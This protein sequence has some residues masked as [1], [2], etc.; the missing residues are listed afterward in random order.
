MGTIPIHLPILQ[1]WSCHNC[2][3][4]CREHAIYITEEERDRI[5]AQ[6][7]TPAQGIPADQPIFNTER[8]WFAKPRIRL[9]HQADG[10]CVFLDDQGLC[11]IHG[12]FGEAA[13]PLAC[14]L[15]P[16]VFHPSGDGVTV[17]LRFSCPSVADNLGAPVQKQQKEIAALADGVLPKPYR[18]PEAPL[19]TDKTRLIWSDTMVV[20]EAL[21]GAFADSETPVQLQLLRALFWMD[22]VQQA[23]F[24]KISGERLAELLTLLKEASAVELPMLPETRPITELITRIQFRQLAG[25]Y[26]RKDT[27]ANIDTSIRGR[28]EL[29][30]TAVQLAG[31]TGGDLPSLGEGLKPVPIQT[32]DESFGE[33]PDRSVEMFRRY[34]RVK[35]QGLH[36]CGPAYYDQPMTE[37]FQALALA[38]AATLWIAKWLAASDGRSEW[39]HADL[40]AALNLI[41]HQHGYSPALGTWEARRRIKNFAATGQIVNLVLYTSLNRPFESRK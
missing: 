12:K 29:L 34:F 6:N 38:F 4:C 10:G 37:G 8:S 33:L 16:Y 20:I 7:W 21:D 1:N 30:K 3:G 23:K 11:R 22:L 31:L 18:W 9:A 5:L 39:T 41:D 24:K 15:Y 14:R 19:L 17:S 36:F 27:E 32:L 28:F 13:K 35:I 26:A 25:R 2:G 40:R